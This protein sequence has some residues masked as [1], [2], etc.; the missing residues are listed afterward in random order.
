MRA[1]VDGTGAVVGIADTG[2]D[3]THP[4]FLDAQGHTRVAWLLD[5]SSAPI[6]KHPDLETQFGTP[7]GQ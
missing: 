2:V 6:G 3:V 7:N 1:D 4:D 5:L